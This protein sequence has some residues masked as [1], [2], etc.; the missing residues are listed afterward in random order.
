LL[1]NRGT[2]GSR[3]FTGNFTN[4]GT[5]TV[6]SLATLSF[7]G[8][9][10]SAG[11]TVSGSHLFQN[12][13]IKVT[14]P[15]TAPTTLVLVGANRLL[16]DN[17]PNVTLW[18]QGSDAGGHATLTLTADTINHGTIRLESVNPAWNSNLNTGT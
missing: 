2:A 10:E 5:V 16:T 11:G 14:A 8:T 12:T 15:S 13:D 7:T 6:G 4:Q 3:S 18:V 1:V 17:P 9:Y